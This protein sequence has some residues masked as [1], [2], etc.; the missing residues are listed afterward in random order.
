MESERVP[1]SSADAALESLTPGALISLTSG[2]LAVDISPAAGG[3]IA[4]IVR[5]DVE[6]LVGYSERD[7]AMIAWGS[8]PM[9]PWAGRVRRGQFNFEGRA[10]QLPVNLGKHAIHGVGLALPWRVEECSAAHVDLSLRLPEDER[11]PFGGTA[12]QRIEASE[13]ALRLRLSVTAGKHAM[14][15]VIGWHPWFR[16]PERLEF[17]PS[18]MYPLDAEGIAVHPLQQPSSGPWDDCFVNTEPVLLE[19]DGQQLRLTS[20]CTHWVVYDRPAHATCIEPQSGPPDAFNLEPAALA[21][22]ASIDAWFLLEWL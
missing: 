19:R 14:P 17:E 2:P 6:W 4:Q 22:G 1:A 7:A 9:L 21:A 8:Y 11:W 5:N 3:R 15:V 16:K 20:N 18:A 12:R 10:F 13:S